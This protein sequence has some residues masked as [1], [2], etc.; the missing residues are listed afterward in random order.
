[1]TFTERWAR[2]AAMRPKRTLAA[3]ITALIVGA[4]LGMALLGGALTTEGNLTGSPDSKQASD[5]IKQRLGREEPLRD[6]VIVR[7]TSETASDPRFRA[8]V[9][10]LHAQLV[11]LGAGTVRV[12][13]SYYQSHDASLVSR[14]GHTT[15]IPIRVAG[16]MATAHEHVGPVLDVVGRANGDQG[17]RVLATGDA[18]IGRDYME[19][20]DSDLRRG[21]GIGI[22]AALVI[23]VLVFGALVAAFVPV[24]M[25]VFAIIL[26][27]ALVAV[28]GHAMPLSYYAINMLT[29]MGL[30][31]GIDY[32]LFIVSRYRE[33]RAR[34]RDKVDAIAASGATASRAVLFSGMT[35]VLALV[36]MLIVPTQVFIS[37]AVGA[38]LVVLVAVIAALTLLP[39]L[40]SL[41]GDRINAV[42]IPFLRQIGRDD[43]QHGMW[44]RVVRFVMRRPASS[45]VLGVSVLLLA[46]I[47]ALDLHTGSAGISTLP[48]NLQS[49][50]GFLILN[51]DFSAGDVSPGEI[52]IDGQITSPAVHA[53]ITKLTAELKTDQRFGR[54]QLETHPRQSLA[55]LTVP[56]AGDPSGKTALASV[57]ALRDTYIPRAFEATDAH[58]VVGGAAA[59]NVDYFAVTDHYLPIVFAL[60]LGL[61]FILL[62]VAF[63]SI[64]VPL[65]S[66][67]MNL[68]SV[69]AAYGLLVLV[70]QKGYLTGVFGFQRV[71]TVEA[72]VPLFLFSVLFGLSMDYQVFLL[73]R[74]RERY[75]ATGAARESVAY[76]IGSTARLIT[77]AALIMVVVFAGFA[78]GELVMF[79]QMGFGL[80]V[81]ILLDATLV[82]T[83]LM[84]A[85]MELLGDWN[86]YLPRFLEWLPTLSVEGVRTPDAAQ[87][88]TTS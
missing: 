78:S 35:V 71:D 36:G 55:I 30:A 42:R 39:A 11:S 22:P 88:A 23:L 82:R 87:P 47:P 49:K 19:V 72:W 4:G 68:L 56:I 62:L 15:L 79:Q 48:N 74:I 40:L 41:L 16:K 25:A 61:S 86:W 64:V 20:S 3:W 8:F 85:T 32:S 6:M 77:G 13:P 45:L 44:G 27:I 34:G 67:A 10:R 24:I 75:D 81:A 80:A 60:V 73:S 18:T 7:S 26:A 57:H 43:G 2:S 83:I 28:V 66:I 53:A 51:R 38:I 54:P 1:M 70:T 58:V 29:F 14:D 33:E 31:V 17:F 59:I 50:Q 52:V 69:G 84:P 37:L 5:L 76:G 12:A 46:A 63:R 21:E 65:T 9:D